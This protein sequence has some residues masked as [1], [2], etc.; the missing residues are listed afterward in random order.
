[1]NSSNVPSHR[2]LNHC[3]TWMNVIVLSVYFFD[4]N[5]IISS[6]GCLRLRKPA[7]HQSYRLSK[8]Y[9]CLLAQSIAHR[10]RVNFMPHV[11]LSLII[12]SNMFAF[13][14]PIAFVCGRLYGKK[15]AALRRLPSA[16]H[17]A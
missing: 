14:L 4:D 15:Y 2:T 9:S 8:S 11:S 5:A 17:C 3:T 6:G 12:I 10:V 13:A 16:E 1:M 7:A